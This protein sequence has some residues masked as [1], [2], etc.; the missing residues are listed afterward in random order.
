MAAVE[1]HTR[2]EVDVE[3]LETL[4][5]APAAGEQPH[6]RRT[7]PRLIGAGA[8]L[9]GW[10]WIAAFAAAGIWE[11]APVGPTPWWADALGIPFSLGA[12]L[13]LVCLLTRKSGLA[14]KTMTAL[15]PVGLVLG[16]TCGT[17]GHHGAAWW[18]SETVIA[19]ALGTAG[20]GWWRAERSQR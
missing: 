15:A 2:T 1:E 20:A 3:A 9:I 8:P 11:P 6:P 5:S 14:A 13:A 10:A 12:L 17:S 19:A 4:W 16:V 7:H 18:V